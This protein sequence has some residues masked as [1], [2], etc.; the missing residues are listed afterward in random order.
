M[1]AVWGRGDPIFGPE[2]RRPS[3]TTPPDAEIHLLDGGHFLL[4]TAGDEVADADPRLPAADSSL[5][6]RNDS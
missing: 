4:E 1:L 2:A 3:P 5:H 6:Q